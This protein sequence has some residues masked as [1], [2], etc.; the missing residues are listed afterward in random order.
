MCIHPGAVAGNIF[1]SKKR[2]REE[3]AM[4]VPLEKRRR[5]ATHVGMLCDRPEVQQCLPQVVIVNHRTAGQRAMGSLTR[6]CP[7]N[8]RL[9][10][11]RSAW[12]NTHVCTWIVNLLGAAL[13]PFLNDFQPILLLDTVN[14]HFSASVLAA[15]RRA[16]IWPLFVPARL[17]WLLQP[18][19]THAFRLYKAFLREAHAE[20]RVLAGVGDLQ[21]AEFLRCVYQT[22]RSVLQCRSWAAAFDAN[23]F[24]DGQAHVS[25]FIRRQLGLTEPLALPASRPTDGSVAVCFPRRAVAPVGR[26]WLTM[27]PPPH[28]HAVPLA[29]APVRRA[30]P[31]L[32]PVILAGRT[33]AET[34][35]LAA[36]A[37]AAS[38]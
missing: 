11:L 4:R 29:R 6:D 17:T 26:I 12:N 3:A 19:D 28:I 9:L 1:A 23:G 35:R 25:G 27:Q 13:R 20:A 33:R 32:A 36:G 34:R 8:V 7:P 38:S 31:P 14:F 18:L 15:C 21:I 22:I 2:P 5:C 10:R 37:A 16:R 30:V 24:G